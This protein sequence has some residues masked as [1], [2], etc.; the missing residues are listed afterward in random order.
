LGTT[1][2]NIQRMLRRVALSHLLI[3]IPGQVVAAIEAR[4]N[5]RL[6]IDET[7]TPAPQRNIDFHTAL[8]SARHA[9]MS[10]AHFAGPRAEIWLAH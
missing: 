10:N 8:D 4:L 9:R 6:P 3:E 1:K 7:D 2:P 5:S